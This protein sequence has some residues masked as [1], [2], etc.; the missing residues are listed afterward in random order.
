MEPGVQDAYER[1]AEALH[2]L[3]WDKMAR[4]EGGR[5][6]VI[7]ADAVARAAV[8]AVWGGWLA[9]WIIDTGGAARAWRARAER[10]EALLKELEARK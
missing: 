10:A 1:A 5:R 6:V 3:D 8:D 9:P 7:N 2:R 4:V